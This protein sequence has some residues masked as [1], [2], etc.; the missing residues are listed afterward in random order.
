MGDAALA[1][2][3]K[4]SLGGQKGSWPLSS[5]TT[6]ELFKCWRLMAQAP[7]NGVTGSVRRRR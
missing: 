2:S 1:A 7:D 3:S 5:V 6:T 4:R